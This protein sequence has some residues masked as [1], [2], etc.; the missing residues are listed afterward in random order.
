M[1]STKKSLNTSDI[2]YFINTH[3]KVVKSRKFNFEGCRIPINTRMNINFIRSWL[4]D[5][6]DT[7]L[8]DFLEFGFPIGAVNADSILSDF[9]KYFIRCW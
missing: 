4:W 7:H 6:E 3:E 9:D 8:C 1:Q 2:N 5:Y